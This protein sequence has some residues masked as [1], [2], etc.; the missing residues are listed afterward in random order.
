[1]R[2]RALVLSGGGAK[3]AFECG[4]IQYLLGDRCLRYDVLCGTSVGAINAAGLAQFVV[5]SEKAASDYLTRLWNEIDTKHVYEKWNFLGLVNV[6]WKTSVYSTQPLRRF[7][8][9]HL[10]PKLVV[11]SGKRLRVSAV[12]MHTGTRRVWDEKATGLV[13]GVLA[14][15]AM[16]LFFEPVKVD[17]DLYVDGGIRQTTPLVD[18][19]SCGALDI[20][21]IVLDETYVEGSF[22]EK[23]SA[24]DIG[25]RTLGTMLNE[26][27]SANLHVAALH[28]RLLEAGVGDTEKSVL[29]VRVLRP[30]IPLGD[31]LDFSPDKVRRE[32]L[33]GYEEAKAAAW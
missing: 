19:I 12:S 28:N 26:I 27:E 23:P 20:D 7:I 1:M 22:P 6:L 15:S 8:S 21:V 24:L 32:M 10:D 5:G 3:G 31:V 17:G 4:A 29:N 13:D 33:Q 16:P 14:S 30:A 25:K 9:A 2:A 11:A 18:A